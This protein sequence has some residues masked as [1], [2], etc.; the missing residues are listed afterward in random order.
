MHT[1]GDRWTPANIYD[2]DEIQLGCRQVCVGSKPSFSQLGLC[3]PRTPQIL[4]GA[5][6]EKSCI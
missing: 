3:V 2:L 1:C 4:Q 5:T 6:G